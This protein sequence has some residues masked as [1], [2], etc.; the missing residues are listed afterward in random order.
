MNGSLFD[1]YKAA[2][3]RGHLAALAGDLEG[4]LEAYGEAARLVPERALPIASQ[5]TVLHRLDRWPEAAEA[6]DL[7]LRLA[8]DDEAALRARA[9]ARAERGLR[10]D[11]AADFERLAF[12]LDV[13]SRSGEAAAAARRAVDLEPSATREVLADRLAAAAA[14]VAGLQPAR[15]MPLP[16]D[17]DDDGLEEPDGSPAIDPDLAGEA[18]NEGAVEAAAEPM[19]RGER[20]AAAAALSARIAELGTQP[21]WV[22]MED[23]AMVAGAT[24]DVDADGRPWPP[25][26]LPSPPPPPIEGPPPDPE[27][28][29]AEAAALIEAGDHAAAHE[30]M[31]LAVKVHRE[32]GRLDAALEASL[33]L[34][35]TAPGDPQVHLALANL[36]LDRGWTSL[37]TEKIELLLRLT[38]LTGDTQATADAHGLAAERLRDDALTTTSPP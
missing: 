2:L 36:Q 28:L 21:S 3:R 15:S 9:V 1:Q 5:G 13:G 25:I 17:R 35:T 22:D 14:H 16:P 4:A 23:R 18:H 37:A 10:P 7:A 11:A 12:V 8:P 6:F 31:L 34:L 19:T 27:T 30:R 26:D 20:D 24:D 33:Q 29:L 32:A 38:S